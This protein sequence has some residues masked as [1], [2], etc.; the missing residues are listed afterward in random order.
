MSD[1]TLQEEQ[2]DPVEDELHA[3]QNIETEVA[4]ESVDYQI[5]RRAAVIIALLSGIAIT[6][7][8]L[9][10]ETR[11]RLVIGFFDQRLLV[12]LLSIFNLLA[13]SLLWAGWQKLDA[14]IFLFFHRHAYR[15]RWLTWTLFTITQFG[16]GVTGLLIAVVIYLSG[17]RRLGI[18]MI[19]GTLSLWI[20]VE[21]VKLIT[22]RPR[23]FHIFSETI[24][25]GWR[26]RGRSFPSGHTT[27]VFFLAILLISYFEFNVFAVAFFYLIA[28]LV[29]FSRVYIGM[30]YP[31]DVIAGALLGSIWGILGA[32]LKDYL[33]GGPV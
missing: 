1:L 9:P 29:G 31:R 17:L 2:T 14:R 24:V 5:R 23:P 6:L 15:A 16:N 28:V 19:L 10:G 30:H 20:I 21:A 7:A 33:L 13:F 32:L 25:I 4:R 11:H 8:S 3:L 22:F 26:E 12:S 18:M 27:Q